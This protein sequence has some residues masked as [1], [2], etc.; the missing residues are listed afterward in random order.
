MVDSA[1]LNNKER[2]KLND[3]HEAL[4][5]R[6]NE[7]T[8]C[9]VGV[10]LADVVFFGDEPDEHPVK[11]DEYYGACMGFSTISV[12]EIDAFGKFF[13]QSDSLDFATNEIKSSFNLNGMG[14]TPSEAID[15]LYNEVIR[16][17]KTNDHKKP[18]IH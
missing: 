4:A 3:T 9:P 6:F 17:L 11:A 16:C 7:M 8:E 18:S 14:A 5:I 10:G 1:K 15:N 12:E 2:K 13:S